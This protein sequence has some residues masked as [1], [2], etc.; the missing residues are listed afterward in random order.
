[1]ATMRPQYTVAIWPL[2]HYTATSLTYDHDTN[3]LLTDT[4]TDRPL[5]GHFINTWPL[6]S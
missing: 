3:R 4:I 6:Y 2:L 5:Y 1:M